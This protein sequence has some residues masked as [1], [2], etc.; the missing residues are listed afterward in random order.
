MNTELL[1]KAQQILEEEVSR[2]EDNVKGGWVSPRLASA[3]LEQ[4]GRALQRITE[5]A[6]QDCTRPCR[7]I[8][9]EHETTMRQLRT[10][11]ARTG[12]P[13]DLLV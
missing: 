11:K 10:A 6:L 12:E 8:N 4:F 7:R 2:Q 13:A 3:M 9:P 1:E 5:G